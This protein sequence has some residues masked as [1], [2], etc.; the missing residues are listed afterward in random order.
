[1]CWFNGD[2]TTRGVDYRVRGVGVQEERYIFIIVVGVVG[3]LK[4]FDTLFF[5]FYRQLL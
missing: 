3:F 4:T 1:M 5:S 2:V